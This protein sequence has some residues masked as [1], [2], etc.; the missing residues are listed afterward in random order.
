MGIEIIYRI[1][2]ANQ[3]PKQTLRLPS[4]PYI[5]AGKE[6]MEAAE[7]REVYSPMNNDYGSGSIALLS[8]PNWVAR[9]GGQG[10]LAQT[11]SWEL[12]MGEEGIGR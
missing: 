8:Q 6:R 3:H 10:A 4:S 2:K 5:P 1:E 11:G 7:N 12:S 9:K